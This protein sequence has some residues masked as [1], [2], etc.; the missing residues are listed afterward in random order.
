MSHAAELG[1]HTLSKYSTGQ[2]GLAA[3]LPLSA[4]YFPSPSADIT[5]NF[6][7]YHSQY[8]FVSLHFADTAAD[9]RNAEFYL[10]I[11][12]VFFLLL[13]LGYIFDIHFELIEIVYILIQLFLFRFEIFSYFIA[14]ISF[15]SSLHCTDDITSSQRAAAI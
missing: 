11:S 9:W 5:R 1:A 7:R 13:N 4:T 2:P 3:T 12:F 14:R 10:Q 6:R 15:S 8:K